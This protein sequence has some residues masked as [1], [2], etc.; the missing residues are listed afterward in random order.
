MYNSGRI[1]IEDELS[2]WRVIRLSKN[3]GDELWFSPQ[4]L[5]KKLGGHGPPRPLPLLRPC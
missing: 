2:V 4:K 1:Y 3:L 5:G